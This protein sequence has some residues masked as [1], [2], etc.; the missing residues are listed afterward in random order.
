MSDEAALSLPVAGLFADSRPRHPSANRDSLASL[1]DLCDRARGPSRD[2][3]ARIAL[4]IFPT[5]RTLRMLSPGVWARPDGSSVRALRYSSSSVAAMTLVPSGHWIECSVDVV[6]RIEI[7]G[8][9]D[10]D[11]IGCGRNDHF[12]LA[13]LAAAL[14]ARSALARL[15]GHG[16]RPVDAAP[17]GAS[18]AEISSRD[19]S[20]ERSVYAGAA[21]Q[22]GR[23][24]LLGALLLAAA[25]FQAFVI[26]AK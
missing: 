20:A 19:A 22:S 3:D 12:P 21:K 1:A 10:A 2:L 25:A 16:P 14:R 4:A 23:T 6:G 7:H 8:P 15:P 13:A 24:W 26:L 5:M 11:P 9:D 17:G 18:P